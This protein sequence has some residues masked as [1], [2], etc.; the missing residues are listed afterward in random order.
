MKALFKI[1]IMYLGKQ[2]MGALGNFA[3]SHEFEICHNKII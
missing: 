1:L 2:Y 3:L